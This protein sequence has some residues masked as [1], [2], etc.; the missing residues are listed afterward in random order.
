MRLYIGEW[1]HTWFYLVSWKIISSCT[2]ALGQGAGRRRERINITHALLSPVMWGALEEGIGENA[3]LWASLATL[4]D[5]RTIYTLE[6]FGYLLGVNPCGEVR[7]FRVPKIGQWLNI[8]NCKVA[9][10]KLAD[11]F[12]NCQVCTSSGICSKLRSWWPMVKHKPEC[13]CKPKVT[14]QL[15]LCHCIKCYVI[16][17][18]R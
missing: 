4:M 8:T 15:N 16:N 9:L 18:Q 1:L 12:H 6:I 2:T 14:S 13:F 7:Y 11:G 17:R 3:P 5:S 10:C